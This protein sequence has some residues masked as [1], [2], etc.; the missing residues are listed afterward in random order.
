MTKGISL[1]IGINHLDK[2]HYRGATTEDPWEGKLEACESDAEAMFNLAKG[3]GFEAELL[4]TDKATRAKVKERIA[5]AATALNKEGGYFLI[6]YSGHGGQV[7]DE[8]GDEKLHTDSNEGAEDTDG[9]DETWCLY[10]A[11]L[12]DDE[13]YDLW[14]G[15]SDKVRIIILSDSCHSGTVAKALGVDEIPEPVAPEGRA[16]RLAPRANLQSTYL[17]HWEFY[18]SLQSSSDRP[19]VSA[20]IMQISATQDS[21]LAVEVQDENPPHGVFTRAVMDAFEFPMRDYIDLFELIL[22]SV[23]NMNPEQTPNMLTFGKEDPAFMKSKP[24]SLA[25]D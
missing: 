5:A 18:D 8:S 9:K 15:F 12:I 17:A 7:S 14:T 19:E 4:L 1:H 6:T 13:L 3:L 22:E 25:D 24:L 11:Q 21:E 2:N 16:Y 10:D 20:S 23:S